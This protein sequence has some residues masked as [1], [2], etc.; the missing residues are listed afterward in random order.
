MS[1]KPFYKVYIVTGFILSGWFYFIPGRIKIP[2][3]TIKKWEAMPIPEKQL[4]RMYFGL[5]LWRKIKQIFKR[6]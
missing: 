5:E 2:D 1:V 4:K 6:E 3:P